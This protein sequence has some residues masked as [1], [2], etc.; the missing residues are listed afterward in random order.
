MTRKDR[1][2]TPSGK[3]EFQLLVEELN[4]YFLKN[5]DI[6]SLYKKELDYLNNKLV[7]YSEEEK[8]IRAIMPYPFVE[9]YDPNNVEVFKDEETQLFFVYLDGKK[10]F[11]HKGYSTAEDVRKSFTYISVEQ[12]PASPHRYLDEDF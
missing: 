11:Y 4:A 10:L 2:A 5:A 6:A 12:D 9:K 7:G 1:K 3:S 8:L